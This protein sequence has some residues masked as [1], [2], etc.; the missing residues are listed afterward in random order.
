[1]HLVRYCDGVAVRLP[2]DVEQHCRLAVRSHHG[3]NRLHSR[4]DGGYVANAYRNASLRRLDDDLPQLCRILHLPV[5]Q[6]EVELM[7]LRQQ[8]GRIDQVGAPHRIQNVADRHPSRQQLRR[9]GRDGELRLLPTL[10]N[11]AG[12][13]VQPVQP[14]LHVVVRHGPQLRLRN[15][16]RG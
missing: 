12:H 1:M 15:R 10:H 3:V 16:V 8:S 9:I 6:G 13:A 4:T 14:R 7:T 11:D 2:V 5:D